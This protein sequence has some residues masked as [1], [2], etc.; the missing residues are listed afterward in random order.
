MSRNHID[1]FFDEKTGDS[2]IIRY[3]FGDQAEI[4]TGIIMLDAGIS[5][6]DNLK[7]ERSKGVIT[8]STIEAFSAAELAAKKSQTAETICRVL[9]MIYSGHLC[10]LSKKPVTINGQ[11]GIIG[12]ILTPNLHQTACLLTFDFHDAKTGCKIA[13]YDLSKIIS[14]EIPF[15][16]NFDAEPVNI[17]LTD[18][19]C[20]LRDF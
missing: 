19:S 17:D 6:G 9:R 1:G 3:F 13:T 2:G 14:D 18:T 10:N 12:E 5:H 20:D 4:P 15:V 7:I 8:I 11:F 16:I